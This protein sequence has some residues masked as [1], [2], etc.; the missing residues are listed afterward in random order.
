VS[1][2]TPGQ[3]PTEET[4]VQDTTATESTLD[5]EA[6]Q[7]ELKRARREAAKYR[8]ELRKSQEAQEAAQEAEMT[9]LERLQA[10]VA[11]LQDRA[12]QAEVNAKRM[13]VRNATTIAATKAG[14]RPDAL[15]I[16]TALIDADTLEV[17]D[18]GNVE[19]LAEAI[20]AIVKE[21]PFLTATDTK[22]R[23][24]PTNPADGAGGE[25]RQQKLDRLFYGHKNTMFGGPGGGV[26]TPEQ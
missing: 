25:T 17:D 11:K 2:E 20:Q 9:E 8:T 19:G 4:D 12:E 7:A 1:E 21:R 23:I 10:T 26:I 18:D 3:E 24:T 16:V 14:V 13:V 15:D 5:A 6:L 22:N